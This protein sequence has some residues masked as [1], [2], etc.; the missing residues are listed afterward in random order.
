M[1]WVKRGNY[2]TVTEYLVGTTKESVDMLRRPEFGSPTGIAGILEAAALVWKEISARSHITIVG[3][4]DSDGLNATA[5]LVRLFRYLG[6]EPGAV[7]PRRMTDGYGLSSS[8]VDRITDGLVIT[9]D[10]GIAAVEEIKALKE[11]GCRIIV[12]DHHL[13]DS[14]L[15]PADIL[16]EPML[17]RRK[18]SSTDTAARGSAI[19]WLC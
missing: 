16:V 8:I 10:N 18:I 12:M 4:Y 1:D 13:P 11:K 5:I 7:I 2:S 3:D 17:S 6:V 19:S 15:P 9:I 14:E